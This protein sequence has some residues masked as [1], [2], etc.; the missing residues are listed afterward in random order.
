MIWGAYRLDFSVIFCILKPGESYINRW[1][2]K[3][4]HLQNYFVNLQKSFNNVFQPK[5]QI[6]IEEVFN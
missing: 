5:S 6:K 2:A 4:S 1:L 3:R